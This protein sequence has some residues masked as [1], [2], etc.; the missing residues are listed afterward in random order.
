MMRGTIGK[1]NAEKVEDKNTLCGLVE[2][3]NKGFGI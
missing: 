3:S 2:R 1:G